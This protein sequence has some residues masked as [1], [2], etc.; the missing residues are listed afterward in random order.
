M[1]P[2]FFHIWLTFYLELT[3]SN[4]YVQIIDTVSKT[5]AHLCI[6]N[7]EGTFDFNLKSFI[8]CFHTLV[9]STSLISE[10][11]LSFLADLTVF[12]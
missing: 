9:E 1:E 11:I 10:L 5:K 12:G 7:A 4:P 8:Y 3:F 2:S 6:R